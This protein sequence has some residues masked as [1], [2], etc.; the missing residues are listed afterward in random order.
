MKTISRFTS[1]DVYILLWLIYYLQGILYPSGSLVSQSLLAIILLWSIFTY[2]RL[3]SKGF[4]KPIFF[5]G[6]N[7]LILTFTVYGLL[8]ITM[9]NELYITE[10]ATREVRNIGYLKEI[11]SSLLPICSFYIFAQEGKLT[12]SSLKKWFYIFLVVGA[13]QFIRTQREALVAAMMQGWTPDGITNNS[14][15]IFVSLIP[16]LLLLRKKPIIQYIGLAV[17]MIFILTSMKRGAIVVGTLMVLLFFS[18]QLRFSSGKKKFGV[19]LLVMLICIAAYFGVDYLLNNNDYFYSR[20]RSTM[21][22]NSSHR[23]EMY[24][25]L[26][27]S[28]VYDSSILQMLFGR[29]AWGTLTVSFNFAHNDWLEILTNQGVLGIFVFIYYWICFLK[30]CKKEYLPSESR[31][32]L[33][34]ILL[35]CFT[36]TIF[37]MSYSDMSIYSTSVL[38]LCLAGGI[39]KSS[40]N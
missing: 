39:G 38:G 25:S 6:F 7:A 17:C 1:C 31:I 30:N 21:E 33:Y 20:I 2:I 32:C 37:S 27:H 19:S 28:F 24:S 34:M 8:L 36:K 4:A 9:G 18:Y 5:K 35:M 29:G 3:Y 13:L 10:G 23:D 11:Y 40:A 16:G 15:Y 22:G 26:W 12:E 14:G